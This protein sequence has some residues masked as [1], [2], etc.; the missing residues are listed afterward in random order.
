MVS[1]SYDARSVSSAEKSLFLGHTY[2]NSRDQRRAK[3]KMEEGYA[4]FLFYLHVLKLQ[5]Y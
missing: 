3:L 1:Y 5:P 2:A 4:N